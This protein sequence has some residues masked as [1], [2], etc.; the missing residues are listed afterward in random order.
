MV[1][2]EYQDVQEPLDHFL[3]QEHLPIQ[4]HHWLHFLLP[5]GERMVLANYQ[6]MQHYKWIN[7]KHLLYVKYILTLSLPHASSIDYS[8][9]QNR[10]SY[11]QIKN[12]QSKQF[13]FE[14][15]FV[16]EF[17]DAERLYIQSP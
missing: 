9:C 4:H 5:N 7:F 11:N 15:F 16:F 1:K 17:F 6:S 14:N 3:N 10:E 13:H 8:F 12:L 2:R